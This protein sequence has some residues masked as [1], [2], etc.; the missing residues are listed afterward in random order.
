MFYLGT[1]NLQGSISDVEHTI[2]NTDTIRIQT[3]EIK[4]QIQFRNWLRK[5]YR[6]NRSSQDP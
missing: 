6:E 1:I 5:T 2:G 3:N 4:N